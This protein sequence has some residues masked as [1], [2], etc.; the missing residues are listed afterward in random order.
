QPLGFSMHRADKDEH[1]SGK[2]KNGLGVFFMINDS[3]CNHNDI[4]EL[5]SFCSPKFLT[6]KC[7]PFY[8]P[9]ELS[10]VIVTAV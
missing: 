6:I 3:L 2:K 4:Q 7:R 8:L 9:R 5:K 1:L 10:S